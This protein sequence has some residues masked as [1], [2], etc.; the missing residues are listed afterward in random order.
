MIV[1]CWCIKCIYGFAFLV[2]IPGL[3]STE[4]IIICRDLGDKLS[5]PPYSLQF[6]GPYISYCFRPTKHL[7][8]SGDA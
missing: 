7:S 5:N 6:L 8:I 3:L 1:I 2:S 4:C